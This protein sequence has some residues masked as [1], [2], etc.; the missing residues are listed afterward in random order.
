MINEKEKKCETG[1]KVYTGGEVKHHKDCIF[2]PES[3]SKMY[4]DLK[5]EN[6]E[7]K[8]KLESIKEIERRKE[9]AERNSPKHF[10]KSWGY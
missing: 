8:D 7:L 9:Q 3:F 1:C 4:D 10:P 6:K 2:Y 5:V